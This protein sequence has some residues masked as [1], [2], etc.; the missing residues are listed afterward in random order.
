MKRFLLV[1]VALCAMAV[2]AFAQSFEGTMTMQMTIPQ[3]G[4]N[5][6]PMTI[7]MKGDKSATSMQTP[8][9]GEMHT[10]TDLQ[11]MKTVMVMGGKMGY[12]VDL[13][14]A[15]EAAASAEPKEVVHPSST[16]KSK[17]INGYACDEF[18]MNIKDGQMDMWMTKDFPKDIMSSISKSMGRNLGGMRSNQ[19]A[20]A[21]G[22]FKELTDKGYAPVQVNMTKDGQVMATVEFVK[23][24]KKS[25]D[26]KDVTVPADV[27]IQPMPDMS[28]R[29]G[30]GH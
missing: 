11:K 24:E 21:E 2:G 30:M 27:T 3:L 9:G 4:G 29:P 23:Y 25:V 8:M 1:V 15:K 26:D 18:I 10:Y 6:I 12:E 19:G 7:Y 17:T 13:N 14:K 20:G 22:A 5:P 28:G 16:G